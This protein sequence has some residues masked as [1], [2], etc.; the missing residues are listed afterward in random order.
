M[1]EQTVLAGFGGQGVLMMGKLL[2]SAAMDEG[3][4]AS[5]LPS[6]GP[7]MRGGTA[8]CIVVVSDEEIGSPVSDACDAIVVM[9]Q[10]SLEKFESKVRPDGTLIINKSIVP[11]ETTRKDVNAHYLE[12]DDIAEKNCDANRSANVVMLGAL[13]S[14]RQILKSD[15]VR[16]AIACSFKSKGQQVIDANLAAFAAGTNA[17]RTEPI[18]PTR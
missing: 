4:Y 8:N 3:L 15:S 9:N 5:W 16:R 17:L 1:L 7:E 11:V 13:Q 6:Y 12:A 10:P 2:A 18:G 14:V